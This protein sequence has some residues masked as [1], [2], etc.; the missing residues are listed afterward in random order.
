MSIMQEIST[1]KVYG[2]AAATTLQAIGQFDILDPGGNVQ[3]LTDQITQV[4]GALGVEVSNLGGSLDGVPIAGIMT[5]II[6]GFAKQ[7]EKWTIGK[8]YKSDKS[9]DDEQERIMEALYASY[10]PADKP[11]LQRGV[12][13]VE[14]AT[15]AIPGN[16]GYY[17]DVRP[18]GLP[19]ILTKEFKPALPVAHSRPGCY[20]APAKKGEG[21]PAGGASAWWRFWPG[22]YPLIYSTDYLTFAG[23][24]GAIQ[25]AYASQLMATMAM[26]PF[27]AI[28]NLLVDGRDIVA[29]L[30][31]FQAWAAKFWTA[32][33]IATGAPI[34][35]ETDYPTLPPGKPYARNTYQRPDGLLTV[36]QPPPGGIT[37]SVM[38][39]T[40]TAVME[41]DAYNFVI[42]T[43]ARFF[44]RREQL[45]A[46]PW[47]WD[48]SIRAA[49]ARSSEASV[50]AALTRKAPPAPEGRDET[51]TV[52]VPGP[53]PVPKNDDDQAQQQQL[54]QPAPPTASAEPS[55]LATAAVIG[56]AAWLL[57]SLT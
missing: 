35:P 30:E 49:A 52:P 38:T 46:R 13:A 5:A 53:K 23:Q 28:G 1:A 57:W 41:P 18:T 48:P 12:F 29:L 33:D 31:T 17:W 34:L 16:G 32:D 45:L 3:L 19:G 43:I 50:Q 25:G 7:I 2:A 22:L 56:G 27:D 36:Y 4:A 6:K 8:G 9:R 37:R 10:L 42:Q 39:D 26:Q 20:R 14:L 15:T 24:G 47:L 55:P 21:K 11:A 40:G 51:D 54:K 44:V